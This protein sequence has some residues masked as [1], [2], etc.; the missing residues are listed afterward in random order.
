MVMTE[1]AGPAGRNR[2]SR[3]VPMTLKIEGEIKN[4]IGVVGK[5]CLVLEYF[6]V[7]LGQQQMPEHLKG[8]KPQ[9]PTI[10][11][12]WLGR[13]LGEEKMSL[14]YIDLEGI[15]K[16]LGREFPNHL[17]KQVWDRFYGTLYLDGNFSVNP[18]KNMLLRDDSATHDDK[19]GIQLVKELHTWWVPPKGGASSNASSRA[20]SPAY[21]ATEAQLARERAVR[22]S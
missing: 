13:L 14:Q 8:G 18:N 17:P 6:P 10:L 3:R 12:R 11:V 2:S 9:E 1:A 20:A 19:P 16:L 15:K 5:W 7:G 4:V 22:R 21:G